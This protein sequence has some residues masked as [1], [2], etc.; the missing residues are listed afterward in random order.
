[1]IKNLGPEDRIG[2]V[3]VAIGL[4]ILIYVGALTGVAV[5]VVG[6]VVAYLLLTALLGACLFYPLI[7][8]DTSVQEQSYTKPDDRIDF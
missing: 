4:G 2:R 5:I 8:I 3:A 1:M 7:G 6:V